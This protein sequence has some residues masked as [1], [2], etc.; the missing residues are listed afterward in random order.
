MAEITKNDLDNAALDTAHLAEIAT[1]TELTATDRLGRQKRTLQGLSQEFPDAMVNAARAAISAGQA[2]AAGSAAHASRVA[3]EAARDTA[4]LSA[5]VYVS[6]AIGVANTASGKY[7]SVPA[8]PDGQFLNVYLNDVGVAAFQRTV[9]Q[10]RT[11]SKRSNVLFGLAGHGG[12]MPWYVDLA[13]NMWSMGINVTEL[14]PWITPSRTLSMWGDS[15]TMFLAQTAAF[16]GAFSG[17]TVRNFGIGAQ[18]SDQVFARQG[19]LPILITLDGNVIP[20]TMSA[21]AV[22]DLNV[23]PLST[24]ADVVER[25]LSGTLCG[26]AGTL[27]RAADD[28]YTFTRSWLGPSLVID[29]QTPFIPDTAYAHETTTFWPGRNDIYADTPLPV[30]QGYITRAVEHLK[31]LDKHFLLLSCMNGSTEYATNMAPTGKANY[32]TEAARYHAIVALNLWMKE[33]YPANYVEVRRALIRQ[34]SPALPQDVVDFER[35]VVPGSLRIDDIHLA[36]N[37]NALVTVLVAAEFKKRGY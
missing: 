10:P 22:V 7:F 24:V 6:T 25:S 31:T 26:V 14:L 4:Q 29:V 30:I 19:A 5:G 37:G 11:V 27:H 15:M 8:G 9:Q 17:R 34:Y 21:V 3:A 12:K 18:T 16:Q 28:A 20:E 35:D 33:T 36:G 1:S 13:G 23:R 2:V 32:P